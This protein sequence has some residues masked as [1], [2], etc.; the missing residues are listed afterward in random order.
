MKSLT[1]ALVLLVVLASCAAKKE[2]ATDTTPREK[3]EV[4]DTVYLASSVKYVFSKMA[5]EG[6]FVTP[7]RV[8]STHINLDANGQRVWSTYEP[9]QPFTFVLNEVPMIDGFKEVIVRM[10]AGDRMMAVI[11]SHLGYG[12]RGNGPIPP[13]ALLHFD[14]EVLSV[15]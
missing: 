8:V 12:E 4:G 9:L 15:Q 14:I 1:Y 2:R 10:R 3:I 5:K 13:N 7:E 11:P 6:D